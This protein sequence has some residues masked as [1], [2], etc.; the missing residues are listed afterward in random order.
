M[1]GERRAMCSIVAAMTPAHSVSIA[2]KRTSPASGSVRISMSAKAWR[3]SSK[4]SVVRCASATRREWLH[5]VGWLYLVVLDPGGRRVG[6]LV[7]GGAHAG[8]L[9]QFDH[10]VYIAAFTRLTN[11]AK[12]AS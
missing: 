3:N 6:R 4:A 7:H 8:N 12:L 2:P 9:S 5:A 10:L 1:R 11:R